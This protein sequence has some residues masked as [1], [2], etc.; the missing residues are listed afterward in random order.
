M[1]EVDKEVNLILSER[2][3]WSPLKDLLLKHLGSYRELTNIIH[4]QVESLR[5]ERNGRKQ[6]ESSK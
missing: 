3:F 1:A 6:T 5:L 4:C 2:T